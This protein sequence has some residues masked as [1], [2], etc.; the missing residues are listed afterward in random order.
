MG[1]GAQHA[2]EYTTKIREKQQVNIVN[3][4]RRAQKGV[5]V[6]HLSVWTCMRMHMYT[7]VVLQTGVLY[8]VVFDVR[9]GAVPLRRRR[10]VEAVTR[11]S[12]GWRLSLSDNPAAVPTARS[13]F[14]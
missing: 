7:T 10:N 3:L 6:R 2:R 12:V 14:R 13:A 11:T 1:R 4:I 8:V 9:L 5:Y